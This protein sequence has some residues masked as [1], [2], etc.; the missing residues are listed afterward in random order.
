MVKADPETALVRAD[1]TP[2]ERDALLA[3]DP[4]RLVAIGVGAELAHDAIFGRDP[5]ARLEPVGTGA[6]G[7]QSGRTRPTGDLGACKTDGGP[8]AIGADSHGRAG[9]G[10]GKEGVNGTTTSAQGRSKSTEWSRTRTSAGGSSHLGTR[11][12]RQ[13]AK[14]DAATSG[15]DGRVRPECQRSRATRQPRSDSE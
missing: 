4:A 5:F 14:P 1:L 15:S 13:D 6:A 10:P 3:W 8:D 9:S 7:G 2:E 11:L 12:H